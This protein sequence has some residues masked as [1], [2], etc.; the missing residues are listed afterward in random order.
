[1]SDVFHYL[2]LDIGA[3]SGRGILGSIGTDGLEMDEVHRFPN[4]PITTE[5]GSL[6]WDLS[7][8]L[9]NVRAAIREA[10]S[11]VPRLDGIAVDTWGVDYGL[12]DAGGQLLEA[13]YHY[14]DARTA[15][16]MDVVF[17]KVP[18]DEVYRRTGI[19]FLELNTLYQLAAAARAGSRALDT[20]HCLLLMPDLITHE[21]C[22]SR[23]AEFTIATTTQ[24]YDPIARDWAR[25]ILQR[26]GIPTH[27]FPPIV[28]SAS[29]VGT[30]TGDPHE[31]RGTP[32]IAA[33]GHDT[34]CAVAAVPSEHEDIAYLS[35]GTWSLL[36]V[37]TPEPILTDEAMRANF[38]NEGGVAGF[39]F[40]KN[41]AGLWVLQEC[42]RSWLAETP[43]LHWQ[44]ITA[45]AEAAPPF[46]TFIDPDDPAFV[47]PGD[48]PSRIA[49]RCTELGLPVPT[50]R[51][52]M[53]RACLE[54]LA[55]RYRITL[56]QLEQITKRNIRTLHVVG[57]G[58]RNSLLC[59]FAAD[60][61]GCEV[62]A[63]PAEATAAGNILVQAIA[64]GRLS[65]LAEARALLRRSVSPMR[66][67]P[68]HPEEWDEPFERF[69]HLTEAQS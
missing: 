4:G 22:G 20:A 36:G 21:L 5:D 66:Y 35:C 13:P 58:S 59:Q 6:R 11:R 52:A 9:T 69:L 28:P 37:E 15:G 65:S 16:M 48:M 49:T 51:G 12:L 68:R 2:A 67:E 42:R 3:E 29:L 43:D 14:R 23:S 61:A 7:A 41:I 33:A 44:T 26:L 53:A 1:M 57:G 45:E 40:L 63:G 8:I 32:I 30:L 19:Q 10:A 31:A 60:A 25:D 50:S 56:R 46:A 38:T 39:R 17:A 47:R 54:G 24:C 34:A 64:T 55:L 27:I 18:K 62:V